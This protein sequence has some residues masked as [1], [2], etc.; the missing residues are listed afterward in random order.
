MVLSRVVHYG[1]GSVNIN[2]EAR[3][4][5][6]SS[7]G[8]KCKFWKQCPNDHCTHSCD[9]HTLSRENGEYFKSIL[10]VSDSSKH[11][12]NSD[13]QE[14]RVQTEH[15]QEEWNRLHRPAHVMCVFTSSLWIDNIKKHK[16]FLI[17]TG[18]FTQPETVSNIIT[19]ASSVSCGRTI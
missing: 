3:F 8:Q 15:K 14:Q 19:P 7:P 13:V 10:N 16:S 9:M 12:T 11:L 1:C 4:M 17:R 5:G 18:Q 2:S 6:T